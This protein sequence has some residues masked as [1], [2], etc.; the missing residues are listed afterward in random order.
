M[1]QYTVT[2]RDEDGSL[3]RTVVEGTSP[4]SARNAALD[5]ID[6]LSSTDIS[7]VAQGSVAQPTLTQGEVPGQGSNIYTLR[8]EDAQ[9][10]LQDID[11]R[12][13]N[14]DDARRQAIS[15]G[16]AESGSNIVSSDEVADT[17]QS[18]VADAQ[19]RALEEQKRLDDLA[20]KEEEDR[21]KELASREASEVLK[22]TMRHTINIAGTNVET[23]RTLI[24]QKPG[25]GGAIYRE[26]L[27]TVPA[28]NI[29]N[30]FIPA[31]TIRQYFIVNADEASNTTDPF[32]HEVSVTRD[33][34]VSG[35]SFANLQASDIQI[36]N[37]RSDEGNQLF[38]RDRDGGGL[39]METPDI[40]NWLIT[41]MRLNNNSIAKNP[42]RSGQSGD[43]TTVR[44]D[45]VSEAT[46]EGQIPEIDTSLSTDVSLQGPL[47]PG[48]FID[49]TPL[50]T[51][52]VERVENLSGEELTS[53]GGV[54]PVAKM[55][56]L[57][58]LEIPLNQ[59]GT[60]KNLDGITA[61]PGFP[62]ELLDPGNLFVKVT[63]SQTLD[64]GT[65]QLFT[66]YEVNP[67]IDAALEIYGNQV[68]SATGIQA[69]S[70]DILQ[71]Q[72]S[73]TGGLLGGP[74][75]SLNIQQLEDIERSSRTIAA[76]G[77]LMTSV[78]T[79]TESAEGVR[80]FVDR[81]TPLGRQELTQEA[82]S[83]SGG[84]IGG[85]YRPVETTDPTTGEVTVSEEF[86]QGFDPQS[87]LASQ[88]AQEL[89]R[90][91]AQNIPSVLQA[92]LEAQQLGQQQSQ[93]EAQRRA[94]LLGQLAEIYS[95][96][97]QLAAI[98]RSGGNP[99]TQLQNELNRALPAGGA[100]SPFN[101]PQNLL[102]MPTA[103]SGTPITTGVPTAQTQTTPVT[104][105]Q[106]PAPS[107]TTSADL[108]A[109]QRE[110]A[111]TINVNDPSTGE[112][113]KMKAS[114]S[115]GQPEYELDP[116]DP[117]G[118]RVRPVPGAFYTIEK[119]DGTTEER[120][121]RNN[122]LGSYG[123]NDPLVFNTLAS[124][125]NYQGPPK[126]FFGFTDE[127]INNSLVEAGRIPS[128]APIAD[129]G[130]TVTPPTTQIRFDTPEVPFYNPNMTEA[131]IPLTNFGQQGVFGA[132]AA[133][134][135]APDEVALRAAQ[136]TP[137]DQG[138]PFTGYQGGNPLGERLGIL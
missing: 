134:G 135:Y 104:A 79:G 62:T 30:T 81:L 49:R 37:S 110:I 35:K 69:S 96:P 11:V 53:F 90:I 43:Y 57:K 34:F 1:A 126:E 91:Q 100:T 117:E 64:D 136:F 42:N 18:S 22:D 85:F 2:Y 28:Y 103:P 80:D 29:G 58:G 54:N 45:A 101:V 82:L 10:N 33:A 39:I 125:S 122:Q 31:E 83:A 14:E 92:Q 70:D 44:N 20:K 27:Y 55:F 16:L 36:L 24:D 132:A 7:F 73:A 8:Q 23:E 17:A 109:A 63:E 77:G 13:D 127:Q 112:R 105:M 130:T 99:L 111:A 56:E 118:R 107:D 65:K 40:P 108:A 66:R 76:T 21:Q 48:E 115:P 15:L 68:S 51:T 32:N 119:L 75:G 84:L 121:I 116:T 9:G 88:Q 78:A 102:N 86:V 26:Y 60:P 113:L 129:Q 47:A 120:F 46:I 93:A 74:A 3:K 38:G 114:S 94:G 61:L 12:G 71:A 95:N 123:L 89:R 41:T 138:T 67:A 98:V 5:K 131:D 19:K 124:S 128:P 25:D 52:E 97:A 72:V 133:G 59:D 87:L 4:I 6:G 137:G 50:T 106:Q